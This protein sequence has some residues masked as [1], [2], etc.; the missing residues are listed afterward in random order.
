LTEHL[1]GLLEF[2]SKEKRLA[3]NLNTTFVNGFFHVIK[4]KGQQQ[5]L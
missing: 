2:G 5:K 1:N 4:T 3:I